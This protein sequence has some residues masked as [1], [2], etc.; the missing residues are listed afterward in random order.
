MSKL[1]L[2]A[3]GV[4]S[5][6]ME[7]MKAKAKKQGLWNLFLPESDL[8]AGLTNFEYAFFAEEMGRVGIASEVFN[9]SAPDTG[10]MEVLVR[11][12]TE[13]QKDKWLT[14]LLNGEIRSAFGMTEPGVASSDATNMEALQCLMAM[15]ILL[16]EKKVVDFG[17]GDPRCSQ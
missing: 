2:V 9:C 1:R 13:A 7:D 11:Y 14:P 15:N 12:G 16:M 17:A 4:Y 5:P 6:I 8:G 3:D 10:N